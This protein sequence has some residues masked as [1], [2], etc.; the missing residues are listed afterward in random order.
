MFPLFSISNWRPFAPAELPAFIATMGTPD[1]QLLRPL[2]CLLHLSEG[3]R[4]SVLMLGSP[5]LLHNRYDRLDTVSDPGWSNTP[6]PF[7]SAPCL[8]LPA[9]VAEPSATSNAIISG[10]HPSQSALSVTIAPRLL[11]CLRIKQPIA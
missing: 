11:S 3:A 4:C 10:L 6:C 1:P 8:L 5:W 7:Y 2:P 9:G